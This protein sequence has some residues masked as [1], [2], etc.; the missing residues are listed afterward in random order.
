MGKL[1]IA[2]WVAAVF[3]ASPHAV[4]RNAGHSGSSHSSGYSSGGHS[5]RGHFA[6][7]HSY[8]RSPRSPSGSRSSPHAGSLGHGRARAFGV[9]RDDHGRIARSPHAKEAFRRSHPCPATG[10]SYGACPGWVVDHVHALKHGGAD[11]PSNMQWQ[12]RSES[13]AKDRWE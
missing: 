11:A 13:K 3:I 8:A 1:G 4:A 12:T 2:A 5:Y 10:K 7:P 9:T 6:L